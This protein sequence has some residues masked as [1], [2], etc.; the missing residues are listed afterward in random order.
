MLSQQASR[1][2]TEMRLKT[3]NRVC[4]NSHRTLHGC[5]S[6]HPFRYQN[7]HRNAENIFRPVSHQQKSLV[8][9]S[10]SQQS[11]CVSQRSRNNHSSSRQS[12]PSQTSR[13]LHQCLPLR[14]GNIRRSPPCPIALR[15]P[16]TDPV[17]RKALITMGSLSQKTTL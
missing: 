10:F 15:P 5:K 4:Q 1:R 11:R 14:H 16:A 7:N 12:K 2:Q 6:R 8:K 17:N 9:W 13:C 3:Q